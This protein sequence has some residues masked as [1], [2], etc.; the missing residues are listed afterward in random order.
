MLTLSSGRRFEEDDA[1]LVVGDFAVFMDGEVGGDQSAGA[2]EL[3]LSAVDPP[4]HRA[5]H[6]ARVRA[7]G[8]VAL[9]YRAE[10]QPVAP[11]SEGDGPLLIEARLPGQRGLGLEGRA[12]ARRGLEGAGE[13]HRPDRGRDRDTGAR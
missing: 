3:A 4:G 5:E 13:S 1:E 7:G 2:R 6:E 10:V 12:A 11:F 9:A 8:N